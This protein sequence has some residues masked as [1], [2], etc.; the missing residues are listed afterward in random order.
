MGIGCLIRSPF[1]LSCLVCSNTKADPST[2]MARIGG[3]VATCLAMQQVHVVYL[4]V[5]LVGV[6][7][8]LFIPM[9]G[10]DNWTRP[11]SQSAVNEKID[12]AGVQSTR[13]AAW[14]SKHHQCN[15]SRLGA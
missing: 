13:V 6:L 10:G 3:A 4:W 9:D 5:P 15:Y 8:C 12:R 11:K 7:A 2:F 1:V 14:A